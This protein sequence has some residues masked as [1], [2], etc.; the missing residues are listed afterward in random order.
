[1]T[2]VWNPKD[3]NVFASASLDGLIRIWSVGS[4]V[5]NFTLEGHA[6][7]V[8]YIDYYQGS[9][10]PFLISGSDDS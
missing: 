9:D 8:N 3:P 5:P 1:M 7:G 10:K 4:P 6:K 2:A